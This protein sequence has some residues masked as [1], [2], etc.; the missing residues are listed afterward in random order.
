MV[1]YPPTARF[2]A[3]LLAHNLQAGDVV[4]RVHHQ[5]LGPVFFGPKP[6]VPPQNRFDAPGG[7]YRIMYAAERLEGAFV[8]TILRRPTGRILRR[9]QVED[10]MWTELRLERALVLAKLFGEGLQFHKID[11]SVSASDNYRATR[12][13]ALALHTD[14][15]EL[16]GLAYRSRFNSDQVCYASSS[17]R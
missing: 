6:G 8:E 17:P 11:P 9:A 13:L 2:P 7:E 16:D 5:S 1:A 12:A 14:F 4:V 10:R 3:G 15:P